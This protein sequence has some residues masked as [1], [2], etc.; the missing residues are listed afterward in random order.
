MDDYLD[1][2]METDDVFPCK[3]CGEILE[4][5]KAFELGTL[6]G[7]FSPFFISASICPSHRGFVG[8]RRLVPLPMPARP[9][10]VES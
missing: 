8:R 7:F 5:G 1:S 10:V 4:E 6:S 3:G 2:P 9:S